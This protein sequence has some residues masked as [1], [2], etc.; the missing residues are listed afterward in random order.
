M[1]FLFLEPFFG[2]SHKDFAEGLKS[3]SRHR[4]D[5]ITLPARF[6]KWRMRGAALYFMKRLP[7]LK[8]YDGMIV[9]DLLSLADLKALSGE[10]LPPV[11]AYFHE[12]Q[13][14]YPLAPGERMDYQF[15]FTNVT[16]A[17]AADRVVFNSHYQLEAFF[18]K[19]PGLIQMMPDARTGWVSEEIRSRSAV[20]YPGCAFEPPGSE[21]NPRAPESTPPLIIWNHRWEFDKN[22]GEFFSALD[23]LRD[24][25]VDFQLALLG[26]NF[27]NIPMEFNSAR[28]KWGDRI[29]QYGYVESKNEYFEWLRKGS[30]VVST[31][32][33]ENF[34]I[35]IIEAIRFRC[36]PILP[37]RLS[38]PEI[39]PTQF[40][41]QVL[42]ENLE[43]LVELLYQTLRNPGAHQETVTE[44]SRC[45]EKFSWKKMIKAYDAE[46]DQLAGPK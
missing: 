26:E 19:L 16:T 12:N 41:Q 44:L 23:H 27:Q 9:T 40:H 7:S 35:S 30:I 3:H 28:R 14:A 20:L 29:V 45:A 18:E 34:G 1:R 32:I 25:G 43:G 10:P 21:M 22:P 15:A 37:N 6:W 38:Y 5:L 33:Q 42:Y 4:I 36:M 46:L 2:G 11:L 17:L 8:E 39:I 31:A 13:L 24:R